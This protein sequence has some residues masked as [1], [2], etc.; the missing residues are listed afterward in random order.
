[1]KS[2]FESFMIALVVVT[3]LTPLVRLLAFRMGAVAHPGGRHVHKKSIARL[4]GLAICAGFFA[5][6]GAVCHAD[7]MAVAA[8]GE[9]RL[10][11]IGLVISAAVICGVG[12]I[13][14][15]RGVRALY[16]LFAQIAV[17]VFSYG[18]GLRI[19][20]V[21]VPLI[22]DIS[23]GPMA[24]PLTVLW[25]V[26]IINAI[27]LIDGLDGLAAGVVFFAAT[28]NLVVS[29]LN[30]VTMVAVLSS[31]VV[32]AVLGFL[33]YNWNPARIFM[34]DSG[35]YLLGYV[36]ATT[37]LLGAQKASTAVSLVVP[38]MALG[39]PI[40]DTLFAMVRRILEQR[41]V[42]SPDRGHIHHRLLDMGLTQR[43]AVIIIYA[44]CGAFTAAAIGVALEHAWQVGV[45]LLGATT[46]MIGLVRFVGY[47]DYLHQRLRQKARLRS[48]DVE[49]LRYAVPELPRRFGDARTESEL[50]RELWRFA[51]TA[52]LGFVE[53]FETGA[54]GERCLSRWPEGFDVD[55]AAG[56]DMLTASYPIGD[57]E[58][59]AA[60]RFGWQ[61]DFGDVTPQS[62][63][64]LQVATDVLAAHLVRVGSPLAPAGSSEPEPV[65]QPLSA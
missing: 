18:C 6:V 20:A 29:C 16:K 59:R 42:F 26:G 52:G 41:S 32:G 50:L 53:I 60:L 9:A 45:A 13:D 47:F 15:I 7:P 19:D 63:I 30:G 28:T 48:R 61:S 39:V 44:V 3:A 27:N 37:A 62:E 23:A 11:V 8:F 5:A 14:D 43:R 51:A 65:A 33:F 46:V 35:S 21:H 22:T 57:G 40:F 2:A 38:V 1:V 17:A 54:S 55:G 4:G 34:G 36:L 31:A 58:A 64:L 56:R 24:L 12:V 49:I 25:I 10:R